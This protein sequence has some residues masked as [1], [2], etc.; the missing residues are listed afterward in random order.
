MAMETDFHS[1]IPPSSPKTAA[2]VQRDS[3]LVLRCSWKHPTLPHSK[4][5]PQ[6]TVVALWAYIGIWIWGGV[7]S[8]FHE[9]AITSSSH[10][11]FIPI[12]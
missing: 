12:L 9:K 6:S 8:F 10:I 5:S 7:A 2:S 4:V 11:Y 3:F 1:K